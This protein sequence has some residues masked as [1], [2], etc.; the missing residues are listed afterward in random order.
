FD[1]VYLNDEQ[2]NLEIYSILRDTKGYMWFGTSNGL[3]RYNGYKVTVF[4]ADH[5]DSSSI[6]DNLVFGVH[7][8]SPGRLFAATFAGV[9][10]SGQQNQAFERYYQE[11]QSTDQF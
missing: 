10:E 5:R 7:E 6:S 1:R 2:F 8:V 9:N 3:V 11:K 4:K